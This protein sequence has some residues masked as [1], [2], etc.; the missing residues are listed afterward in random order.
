MGLRLNGFARPRLG[1]AAGA[2][3]GAGS[4]SP[5][6]IS[7][8]GAYA[9]IAG[10]SSSAGIAAFLGLRLNGLLIGALALGHRG[11]NGYRER[12]L[13][14]G[15]LGRGR[16]RDGGGRVRGGH[17]L[18][19]QRG[20]RGPLGLA[21]ER[22]REAALGLGHR[23]G[24]GCRECLLELGV[25]GRGRGL[26]GGGSVRGDRGLLVQ[27][28]GSLSR[29]DRL[30]LHHGQRGHLLGLALEECRHRALGL[31]LASSLRRDARLLG[32]LRRHRRRHGLRGGQGGSGLGLGL[33]CYLRRRLGDRL[34]RG[35]RGGHGL[36]RSCDLD[37]RHQGLG[38]NRSFDLGDG[39][40]GCDHGFR[41]RRRAPASRRPARPAWA[42]G[43]TGRPPP[44][45]EHGGSPPEPGLRP[46]AAPRAP[47]RSALLR[48]AA[49]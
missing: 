46:Q 36:G 42:C 11:G 19:V 30:L 17:G 14:L 21:L 24:N 38:P 40:G 48:S 15:V 28:R 37:G 1:L 18:L 4:A 12:L 23:G 20:N 13:E 26:D 41:L 27:R 22:V 16:C 39:F 43:R 25:L 35:D 31:G 32:S 33:G 2:A 47:R 29:Y 49:A 9:A 8:A 7:A 3:T 34:G 44:S 5:R 6:S 45:C 10:S